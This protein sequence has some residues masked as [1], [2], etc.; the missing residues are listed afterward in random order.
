MSDYKADKHSRVANMTSPPGTDHDSS[1]DVANINEFTGNL[2]TDN[3]IPSPTPSDE[4]IR[5]RSNHHDLHVREVIDM[6]KRLGLDSPTG[7]STAE[8]ISNEVVQTDDEHKTTLSDIDV[9]ACARDGKTLA[10]DTE[11]IGLQQS[12][13]SGIAPRMISGE[14]T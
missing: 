5:T 8:T 11:P 10:S 9:P 4:A 12:D 7:Q 3:K 1:R 6:T 2:H 13:G 14:E